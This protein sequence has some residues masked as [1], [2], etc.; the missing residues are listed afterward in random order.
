[1]CFLVTL[2]SQQI[3]NVLISKIFPFQIIFRALEGL[4][5]G[6]TS[7]FLTQVS[8]GLLCPSTLNSSGC[9]LSPPKNKVR[10]NKDQKVQRLVSKLQIRASLLLFIQI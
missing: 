6:S 5:Y 10:G 7:N 1:M 4:F 3:M 2:Y 8:I 9:Q